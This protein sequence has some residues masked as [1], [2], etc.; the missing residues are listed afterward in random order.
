MK[1]VNLETIIDTLSWHKI[2]Q[3]NGFNLIRAKPKL[4]R[5]QKRAHKSS[6]SRRG[7]QKSFTLTIHWNL[8]KPVKIYPGIIERQHL[9]VQK[10]MGLLRERYAGLKKGSLLYCGNQ[11]WMKKWWAD[12]MECYCCLRIISRSLVWLEEHFV[13][14]DSANHSK[15]Q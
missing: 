8:T 10:H 14:G 7:T 15:D 9:T 1:D 11:V 13:N 6:W 12:S 4:L 5:K 3:L 2:W